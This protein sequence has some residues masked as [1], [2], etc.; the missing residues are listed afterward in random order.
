MINFWVT[1]QDF[2]KGYIEN[3]ERGLSTRKGS[4]F[5]RALAPIEMRK[6]HSE[7]PAALGG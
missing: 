4:R 5:L 6:M 2:E 7:G 1:I 3:K